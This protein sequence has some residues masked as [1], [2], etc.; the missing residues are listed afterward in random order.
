MSPRKA[1]KNE[2]TREMIME[3]A[4]ELFVTI[5]YEQT[6]MRQIAKRLNY[7]H[8]AIYYHFKDK[9]ELF[10]A[11]VNVDFALLDEKLAETMEKDICD[12]DKLQE[13]LFRYIEFGL[14]NQS[15]YEIMFLIKD[16]KIRSYLNEAPNKSYERFAKALSE[17][18]QDISIKDIWSVF[19]S[20]HGFVT[21]YC[22]YVQ[23]FEDVKQLAISHVAFI[24]KGL[25]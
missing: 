17:L 23:S 11:I 9:A 25:N 16:E 4:R 1:V 2:L 5:G 24:M 10:L 20:L 13:V 21:H 14:N 15:Q 18:K 12:N 3:V 19:L 6:S 8:G 7:S 22:R